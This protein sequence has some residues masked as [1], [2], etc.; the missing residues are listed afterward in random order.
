[1]LDGQP[2]GESPEAKKSIVMIPVLAEDVV[3][4]ARRRKAKVLTAAIAVGILVWHLHQRTVDP[5]RARQAYTDG[6]RLVR[7]TRYEQAILNFDRAIDLQSNFADAYRMRGRAFVSIGQPDNG[8][9][10]FKKVMTIDPVDATVFV[11]RGFAYLDKK[12][13]D[14][15]MADASYALALDGNLARAYNLRASAVR[16]AG[17]PVKAL[18][19]FSRAVKLE[20]NLDNYFQRAA[21]Y[22]LL[23][24]H[25]HAVEDLNQALA[26][27]PREPHLYFARAQ[28][29]AALG[30]SRGALEDIRAGRKIEG[31]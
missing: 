4:G 20:P 15:A 19:D 5:V 2:P 10:D 29:R 17:D 7:D 13:W 22:Q 21:T 9:P 27:W 12:E 25:R 24:D 3:R 14:R 1:M 31:W 28:S 8:I 23:N 11:Q 6:V 16:S 18:G 30:D 26:A